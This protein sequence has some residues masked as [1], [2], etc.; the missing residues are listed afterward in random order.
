MQRQQPELL[1]IQDFA[2]ALQVTTA[3][4]RRWITERKITTVKLGR[5]VRI[6]ANEIERLVAK[7][8]RLAQGSTK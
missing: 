5:L 1:T 6:P 7:G 3:C 4:V 8:T 2:S